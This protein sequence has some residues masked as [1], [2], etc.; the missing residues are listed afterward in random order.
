MQYPKATK[1]LGARNAD[2]GHAGLE[3]SA[4][5]DTHAL[6]RLALCLVNRRRLGHAQR[7]LCAHVAGAAHMDGRGGGADGHDARHPRH[8]RGTRKH[9]QLH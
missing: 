5:I 1:P 6:E 7:Q 2:V 8:K 4:H 3:E 9:V